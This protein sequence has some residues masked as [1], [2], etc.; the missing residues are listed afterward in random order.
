M[1]FFSKH[2][3][4][5]TAIALLCLIPRADAQVRGSGLMV[6]PTRVELDKRT[7]SMSLSLIN[8]GSEAGTYRIQTLNSRMTES[9]ERKTVVGEPEAGELFADKLIRFAPRQIKLKPGEQQAVRVMARI[10]NDLKEGEYRTGLN[11]QWVPEPGEPDIGK[12]ASDSEGISVKI[13]FSFGITVPVILR[14]GELKA[15]GKIAKLEIKTDESQNKNIEII[16]EREGNHSLYGNF[17]VFRVLSA[18]KEELVSVVN[19]VA[20]YV[21][22]PR[23]I[24]TMKLPADKLASAKPGKDKLRVEYREPRDSGGKLIAEATLSL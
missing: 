16:V 3:I 24:F 17:S 23:R 20:V 11:F 14:H 18:D 21:P 8:N 9:G 12:T 13:D 22:N 2:L 15:T 5:A 10:P 1:R 6:A 7:Q 19:G 4:F